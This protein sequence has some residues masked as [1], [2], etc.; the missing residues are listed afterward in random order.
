MTDEAIFDNGR[1][2]ND[3]ILGLVDLGDG[4]VATKSVP[5]DP[6]TG[7]PLDVSAATLVKEIDSSPLS[8]SLSAIGT[9]FTA[10]MD[11][12]GSLSFQVLGTF[13]GAVIQVETSDDNINFTSIN[14]MALNT[15][16]VSIWGSQFGALGIYR[17]ERALRYTKISLTSISTGTVEIVGH[18]G[19]APVVPAQ[20]SSDGNVV[21]HPHAIPT[22]WWVYAAASGGI[23]NTTPVTLRAANPSYNNHLI[24]FT[25]RNTHASVDTEL[26]IKTASTVVWR[27]KLKAGGP[28]AK[29]DGLIRTA[30]V[31]EAITAECGTTGSEVYINAQGWFGR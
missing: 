15:A 17:A 22:R 16:P 31:N 23:V 27:E 2:T 5:V 28:T 19:H 12:Y 29:F 7:L 30:N 18:K 6:A 8:A 1:L 10:D 25:A 13:T 21:S 4:T 20:R 26:I 11:G 9:F 14:V 3:L 24:G